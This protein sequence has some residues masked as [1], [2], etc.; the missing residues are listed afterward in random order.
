M[1]KVVSEDVL[2]VQAL[3]LP[4]TSL[5]RGRTGASDCVMLPGARGSLRIGTWLVPARL[6]GRSTWPW[7]RLGGLIAPFFSFILCSSNK[8]LALH[9]YLV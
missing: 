4:C 7:T 9:E 2:A 1:S 5:S 8:L 6:H 3:L